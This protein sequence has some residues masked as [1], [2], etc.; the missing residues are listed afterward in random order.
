MD[1]L[2]FIISNHTAYINDF[3]K[4]EWKKVSFN[5]RDFYELYCHYD[6]NELID[7]LNYPLN[8]NKFKNTNIIILYDEPIIYQYMYKVKDRFKLANSVTIS[9]L[10]SAILY[11]LCLNNLYKNQIILVE[12]VFYKVEISDRFLTLNE[13]EEEEEYLQIDAMEISK[14]LIE[15]KNIELPLNDMDIENINHIF[16]FNNIDTEFNKCLIL[17]PATI[18]ATET[19]VKKFLEVNDSLIK[20]SLLR[21]GTAVKIGDVLFKYYHKVKGFL[22]TTT[23]I[24]E[25]RAEIEGIFFWDN[26]QDGNVWANKDEVIGEIKIK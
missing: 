22:K 13:V 2:I 19:P 20:D 21:D 4:G 25:K 15:E 9:C 1:T 6:A 10:D 14:V 17:S 7:F 5:K 12:N 16:T 26:R 18:T 11:Y 3:Y 8:Y 24:L 23:T